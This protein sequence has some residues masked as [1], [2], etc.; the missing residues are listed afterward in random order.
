MVRYMVACTY[1]I[2]FS[3]QH[4]TQIRYRYATDTQQIRNRYAAQIR[5]RYETDTQQI[6]VFITDTQQIRNRYETD[7]RGGNSPRICTDTR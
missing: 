5:N 6:R 2:L 1:K 3:F 4:I 7:M